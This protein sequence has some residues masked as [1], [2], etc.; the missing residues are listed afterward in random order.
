MEITKKLES[1]K[2]V[3]NFYEKL[4]KDLLEHSEQGVPSTAFSG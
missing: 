4:R 1:K 3:K 2:L